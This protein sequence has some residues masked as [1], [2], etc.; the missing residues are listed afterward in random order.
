MSDELSGAL[1]ERYKKLSREKAVER[2]YAIKIQNNKMLS[3]TGSAIVRH[4]KHKKGIYM[5][6]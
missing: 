5:E 2:K 6:K 1:E 3:S 4:R